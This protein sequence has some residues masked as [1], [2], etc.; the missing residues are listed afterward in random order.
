MIIK[1]AMTKIMF[2]I[3]KLTEKYPDNKQIQNIGIKD[4]IIAIPPI[5][6]IGLL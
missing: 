5:R 4:I 6:E 3:R 2:S 1:V